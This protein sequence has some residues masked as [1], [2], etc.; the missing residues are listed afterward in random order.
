MPFMDKSEL[1]EIADIRR[2]YKYRCW[3]VSTVSLANVVCIACLI[4]NFFRYSKFKKFS[5]S[6][7][8]FLTSH[9]LGMYVVEEEASNLSNKFIEKYKENFFNSNYSKN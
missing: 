4:R 7:S 9:Y 1:T 2:Q 6:T 5:I 3:Y 8:T